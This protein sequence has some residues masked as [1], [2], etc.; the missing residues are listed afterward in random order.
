M[1]PILLRFFLSSWIATAI[2]GL[3]LTGIRYFLV[4]LN[5]FSVLRHP[6]QSEVR[7]VHLYAS[8]AVVFAL[9]AILIEHVQPWLHKKSKGR[10]TGI[11]MLIFM[12]I[13]IFSG[14][15]IQTS[16]SEVAR[17]IAVAAHTVSSLLFLLFFILH[18]WSV[19]RFRRSRFIALLLLLAGGTFV[20]LILR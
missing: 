2:S 17:E 13:M 15:M 1:N 11:L 20:F 19:R 6:Y 9:G 3:I 18:Q 5:E 10:K 14:V 16:V 12:P 4:P 8:F 7:I